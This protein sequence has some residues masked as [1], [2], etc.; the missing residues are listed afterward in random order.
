M[1]CLIGKR[2]RFLPSCFAMPRETP[3][4]SI[5]TR[6]KREAP[7]YPQPSGQILVWLG[8]SVPTSVLDRSGRSPRIL[9]NEQISLRSVRLGPPVRRCRRR[10]FATQRTRSDRTQGAAPT[11]RPRT[12]PIKA[13]G[14][15]GAGLKSAALEPTR[16]KFREWPIRLYDPDSREEIG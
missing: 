13:V 2:A 6:V 10:I 1:T 11:V 3:L 5:A 9:A 15:G 16:G 14:R 12:R 4:A 8:S 7:S